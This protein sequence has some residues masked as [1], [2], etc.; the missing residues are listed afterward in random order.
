[1]HG[2]RFYDSI[3]SGYFAFNHHFGDTDHGITFRLVPSMTMI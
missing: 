1:M 2:G 3:D